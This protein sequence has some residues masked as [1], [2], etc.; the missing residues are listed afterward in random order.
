MLLFPS[1][2]VSASFPAKYLRQGFS[3]VTGHNNIHPTTTDQN[4]QDQYSQYN[5]DYE[6]QPPGTVQP[7]PG[8]PSIPE[9]QQPLTIGG[10]IPPP[11]GY[12]WPDIY[13]LCTQ[14]WRYR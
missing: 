14:G 6:P 12:A 10:Q 11:R 2:H 5:P 3:L 7:I 1:I 9:P 13:R 4:L 8:V